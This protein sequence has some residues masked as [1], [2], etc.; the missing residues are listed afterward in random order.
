MK[1]DGTQGG[2][3][4]KALQL[5]ADGSGHWAQCRVMG[6]NGE[7]EKFEIDWLASDSPEP[8]YLHRMHICFQAEDPFLFVE[9]VADA[10]QRRADVE[11]ALLYKLY[12]DCMP[13][14]DL[15]PL[16]SEQCN[17]VLGLALNS[18]TLRQS[19]L[20]TSVLM[21]EISFDYVRAMNRIVLGAAA[22]R[23][24]DPAN[25]STPANSASEMVRQLKPPKED[26]PRPP[27]PQGTIQLE[28]DPGAFR[29]RFSEFLFNSFLTKPEIIK[30][31][32][33]VKAECLKV[34]PEKS[35]F[36]FVTKT[37]RSDEFQQQQKMATRRRPPRW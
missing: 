21:N 22:K 15:K 8:R 5:Q 34:Y 14:D 33:Q 13:S 10:H 2:L 16:D 23:A 12:C 19:T 20:D 9:R 29:E 27:P 31:I 37:V 25:T 26:P 30:V 36:S 32:V 7:L 35:F 18:K 4:A 24:Q 1:S 6:F 17:R 11:S 3:P 28:Q